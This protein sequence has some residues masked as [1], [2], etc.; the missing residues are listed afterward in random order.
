MELIIDLNIKII[1]KY[2][3]QLCRFSN[4]P[5]RLVDADVYFPAL[6]AIY[7]A[8]HSVN[9]QQTYLRSQEHSGG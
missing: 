4:F 3:V 7:A 1:A 2:E 5:T 8:L 9:A 6:I